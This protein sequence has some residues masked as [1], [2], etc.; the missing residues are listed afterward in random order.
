VCAANEWSVF[1]QAR[2]AYE[3]GLAMG[4]IQ[5]IYEIDLIAPGDLSSQCDALDVKTEWLLC[6]ERRIH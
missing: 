5:R 4:G 6:W 3:L 1:Q 2:L